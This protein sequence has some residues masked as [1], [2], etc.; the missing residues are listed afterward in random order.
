LIAADAKNADIIKPLLRGKDIKRYHYQFDSWYI[1]NAHNGVREASIPRVDVPNDYPLIYKHLQ[2]Y[3][4]ELVERQDKGEHWTNLRNCAFLEEF[5]KPKIVW[6]EISD[7]ANYAYDDRGMYLTNSAYFLTVADHSPYSLKYLLA[8]LN[9]KVSDY[10]FSHFSAKIAGGRMRYTKQYVEK[11]IIPHLSKEEQQPFEMLV[12]YILFLKSQNL[13]DT[14]DK[15][16]SYYF[17]HII[18]LAVFEVFFPNEM[19][20]AGFH[21]LATL[22]NLPAATLENIRAKYKDFQ[23]I[24]HPIRNAVSTIKNYRPFGD[25][26][27][28]L[29]HLDK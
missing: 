28:H 25:I 1:I 5:E 8:I 13:T 12:D 19:D 21:I 15:V 2:K 3:E 10:Y 7:K 4:K 23:D 11:I 16:M 22:Q 24:T 26:Y 20:K 14:K 18:D 27:E 6:I 9:S 17:E 29:N